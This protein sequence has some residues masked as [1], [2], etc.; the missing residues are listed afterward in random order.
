MIL[1]A[2]QISAD[3]S[4]T[5]YSH[6]VVFSSYI[7]VLFEVLVLVLDIILGKSGRGTLSTLPI[8]WL[9]FFNNIVNR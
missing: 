2:M 6:Q 9:F 5:K 7:I 3:S 8:P 4:L 1:T